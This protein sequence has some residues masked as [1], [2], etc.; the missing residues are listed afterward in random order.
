M[1]NFRNLRSASTSSKYTFREESPPLNVR[2]AA[3]FAI[4]SWFD[5]KQY[6]DPSAVVRRSAPGLI[7]VQHHKFQT[8]GSDLYLTLLAYFEVSSGSAKFDDV[9]CLIIGKS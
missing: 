6:L 1:F 3:E 7:L 5:K 9:R 2:T 8:L 4:K